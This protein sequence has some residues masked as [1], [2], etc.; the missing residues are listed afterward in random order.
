MSRPAPAH[1]P[2]EQ[3]LPTL[4]PLG[5]VVVRLGAVGSEWDEA[6]A[7]AVGPKGRVIALSG[8]ETPADCLNAL[9]ER[10]DL[11]ALHLVIVGPLLN[12]V[13]VLRL[14]SR[15]L[16]AF[17]PAVALLGGP[18]QRDSISDAMLAELHYEKRSLPDGL[19]VLI[20]KDD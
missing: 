7:K 19:A 12:A 1:Y 3:D 16:A 11:P 20:P 2:P 17:G 6:L 18:Q 8:G 15:A 14:A 10:A 4:L 9:V 13:R 5:G